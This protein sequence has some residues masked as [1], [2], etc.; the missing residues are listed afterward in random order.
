MHDWLTSVLAAHHAGACITLPA[1]PLPGHGVAL[2]FSPHPDDPDAV[3]ITLRGLRDGGWTVHWGVLSYSWLGV[4]DEEAVDHA[5]KGRL[6]AAEQRASAA[7]F[8]LPNDRL[9]FLDLTAGTDGNIADT[10]DN[11]AR[12]SA[13]LY[14]V[15]P[16]LVLLPY[17]DDTNADHRLVARWLTAW[18]CARD[19]ATVAF[20]NED[21]KSLDFRPDLQVTFSE[22]DAAWKAD[23]LE[24]HR[25]Q[26]LRNQATRGITFAERILAVNR[27]DGGYAERFRVDVFTPSATPAV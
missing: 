12:A 10:A 21:P 2:A 17:G 20:F 11:F 15:A 26:S 3:A 16:D 9:T 1:G 13:F 22:E 6:R 7:L 27:Q 4:R 14:T 24:C 8:G 5:E 25:T 18:A 19:R 23:L